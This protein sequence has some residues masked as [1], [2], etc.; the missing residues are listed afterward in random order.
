MLN[1]Y[2]LHLS[3]SRKISRSSLPGRYTYFTSPTKVEYDGWA[4][5]EDYHVESFT[6]VTCHW[7]TPCP[8]IRFVPASTSVLLTLNGCYIVQLDNLVFGKKHQ[9]P[10]FA[11]YHAPRR[12]FGIEVLP[13]DI[14]VSTFIGRSEQD[15][16][17]YGQ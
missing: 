6:A 7:P 10:S 17:R 3:T 4:G 15:A 13:L 16:S 5:N 8:P 11:I 2:H 12:L 14:L 9:M 1:H